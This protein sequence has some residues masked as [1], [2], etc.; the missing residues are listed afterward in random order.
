MIRPSSGMARALAM[1]VLVVGL[2]GIGQFVVRPVVAWHQSV[3]A[4]LAD[5]LAEIARLDQTLLALAA[6]RQAL[7]G[8][9]DLDLI[10]A[11]EQSGQASAMV[12][13]RLSD[14]ARDQGLALRS[15]SP[16]PVRDLPLAQGVGFR[17]ELEAS[18]DRLIPYLV[19]LEHS[20]P[21]LVIERATLRRLTRAGEPVDSPAA[22]SLQPELFVQIDVIA[23]VQIAAAE[24][25]DDT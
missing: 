16:L 25:E 11:A 4:R 20:I 23:P 22:P 14:L 3:N 1:A 17:I 9:H 19:A 10:W 21:L 12:Q 5:T 7:T 24:G 15:I 8:S 2:L 18:L 6:E 13:G